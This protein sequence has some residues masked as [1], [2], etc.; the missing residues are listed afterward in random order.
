MQGPWAVVETVGGRTDG[1]FPF[2]RSSRLRLWRWGEPPGHTA[3]KPTPEHPCACLS[4]Q[5]CT[6]PY[7][8]TFTAQDPS[9]PL[10]DGAGLCEDYCLDMWQTCRRPLP[11][12]VS[13]LRALGAGRAT[14]RQ[15]C[16]SLSLGP[17]PTT[18]S[19]A[20]W[21]TRTSTPTWAAWWLTP[22]LP[23]AVPG[24]GG[25]GLTQPRGHGP[26]GTKHPLWP[27]SWGWC[28]STLPGRSRLDQL[29]EHQPRRASPLALGG[30]GG[31]SLGLAFRSFRLCGKL[32]YYSVG[33]G[34]GQWIRISGIQGLGG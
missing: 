20:C 34:F 8:A 1:V 3:G 17:T 19:R 10:R 26:A 11:A 16:R 30:D 13:G 33:V 7:A 29:P 2:Y 4:L 24:G 28:R 15:L 21:S 12:P 23:A 32:V 18:A 25:R 31:V 14:Q 9:T 27:S 6:R 22:E 5:E